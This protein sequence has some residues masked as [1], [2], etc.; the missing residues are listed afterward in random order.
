MKD[1]K[2]KKSILGDITNT[3]KSEAKKFVDKTGKGIQATKTN[4]SKI[5]EAQKIKSNNKEIDNKILEHKYNIG[6]FIYDNEIEIDDGIVISTINS[7]DRLI[8]EIEEL[9]GNKNG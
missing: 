8:D 3:L 5:I 6:R 1:S 7:I 4:I 2:E 9:E